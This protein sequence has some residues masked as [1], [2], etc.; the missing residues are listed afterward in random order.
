MNN[1]I[2]ET[3]HRDLSKMKRQ[4]NIQQEKEYDKYPPN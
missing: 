2:N 4:R 3:K 1:A